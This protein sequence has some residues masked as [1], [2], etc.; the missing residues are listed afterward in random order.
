MIDRALA[1]ATLAIDL[2]AIAA[3]WRQLRDRVAP[4]ACAAVVKADAYGLGMERVAPAL[5]RAGCER[6]VVATAEEGLALRRCLSEWAA[7]AADP[8]QSR[9]R[10]EISVLAGAP[11]GAEALFVAEELLPVLN[12]PSDIE[13]WTAA[14]G[15]LDRALPA[16][17]HLDTGMSR[18][19]LT[20]AETD[21]L[22]GEPGRLA[23]I[24]LRFWMSHLAC[25]DDPEN[26][27]NGEQLAEFEAA[28]ARLPRA[29]TSLANS[30]GIFLGCRWYGDIVRPGV[31]LYGGHPHPGRLPAEPNPMAQVLHLEGRIL[32]VREIDS[33]RS[34]GYG[35]THRADGRRRIATV[36]V[37]YADGLHRTLSNTGFGVLGG[38]SVPIVGRVSMDLVTFD[39]TT[40]PEAVAQPGAGVTLLGGEASIDAVARAAG[41]IAYEILTS[42]GRRYHRVYL[43]GA[44]A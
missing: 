44:P 38:A 32:Q 6:F 12:G 26:P 31:A 5:W 21:A 8:A 10:P 18:L 37:G 42:L 7:A 35:A 22:A 20:P 40:V 43:D 17:I 11:R 13:A 24:D 34:V 14:A 29:A 1:G 41:T 3:N 19:G 16:A 33:G 15:R 36:A 4:A 2:G 23:G 30:S 27:L 25:A 28:L 9:G 39:V